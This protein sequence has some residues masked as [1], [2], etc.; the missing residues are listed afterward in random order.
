MRA[1]N[2][3]A[4]TDA[5]KRRHPGVVIYGIGDAAHKLSASDHNEDDT[6]GSKAAQSD[7]DSNP[8]HR[9]ID[10]M[11]GPAFT[12]EDGDRLVADLLADPVARARLLNIIWYRRIWSRSWGWTA[13]TYTGSDPH[14]NHPHIS[15]W[16]ADDENAAGW[17]AVDGASGG[18]ASM[19]SKLGDSGENVQFIQVCLNQTG[20]GPLTEDGNF[21]PA[22]STA[23]LKMRKALGSGVS[24][25]DVMDAHA[26]NQLFIHLIRHWQLKTPGPQ[27]PEG[28]RGPA[29]APGAPGAPG[30]P[31]APGT[32]GTPGEPGQPGRDGTLIL[33]ERVVFEAIVK[34]AE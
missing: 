6:V 19:F 28:P 7:A 17:P 11:V 5:I 16:A 4:L 27:G 13:R 30:Q 12:K 9:A 29:G 15:G 2:M 1:R 18:W 23:I 22:T 3:Q 33:P 26:L 14:T 24:S 10:V 34:P 25:G 32:P 8:E 31:G 20:F 21:G